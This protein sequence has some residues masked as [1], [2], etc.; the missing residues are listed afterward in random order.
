MMQSIQKDQQ[1]Y[2]RP[3]V[4]EIKTIKYHFKMFEDGKRIMF[5]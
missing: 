4:V 2:I 1:K 3:K 5:V